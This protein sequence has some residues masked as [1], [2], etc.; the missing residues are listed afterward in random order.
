MT[1]TS[2]IGKATIAGKDQ[3]VKA[4][5]LMVVPAGTQ[6]QFVNT[7]PTPLVGCFPSYAPPPILDKEKKQ[8]DI[9]APRSSIQYIPLRNTILNLC[10]KPKKRAMRKRRMGKTRHQ[11]GAG[12]QKQRTRRTALSIRAESIEYI[13]I[14]HRSEQHCPTPKCVLALPNDSPLD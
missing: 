1:F 13:K 2:G 6:H 7:G 10:T 12:N 8:V 9:I 14:L 11:T 3:D 5:D 4:G